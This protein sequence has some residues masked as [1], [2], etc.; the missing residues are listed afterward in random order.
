MAGVENNELFTWLQ[1]REELEYTLPSDAEKPYKARATSR[2]DTPEFTAIFGSVKRHVLILKGVH[3]VFR[4]QG[5]EADLKT[6]ATSKASDCVEILCD[7]LQSLVHS[8]V[9]MY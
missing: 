6:I 5:Y 3:T 4:R 8:E 7:T 2:F 9:S 1:D